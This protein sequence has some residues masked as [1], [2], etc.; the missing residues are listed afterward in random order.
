M[1]AHSCFPTNYLSPSPA[2]GLPGSLFTWAAPLRAPSP[3]LLA[4]PVPPPRTREKYAGYVWNASILLADMV[5]AREIEVE[6][7][8]VLELGCGLGLPGLVAARMGA[9]LVALTDYDQADS[10]GDTARAACEALPFALHPRVH[11]HPHT[12]GTSVAPLLRLSPS[13]DILLLADCVWSPSL[14]APLASSLGALLRACP[15]AMVHFS[16]GFHTGRAVVAAFLRAAAEEGVVPRKAREWREVSV[17]GETRAWDWARVQR[18]EAGK[19]EA[20]E[21]QEE[22]NRWT[23]YGTLGLQE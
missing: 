12:W 3:L 19:E 18:V 11:V 13:F 7:K 4:L 14:H 16:A 23:L 21:R 1:S 15:H 5:A 22:R 6:G 20:E 9:E 10:L 17:E 2:H 8:R